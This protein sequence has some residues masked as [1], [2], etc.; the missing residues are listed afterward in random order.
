VLAWL[1]NHVV[2][3]SFS[4][5]RLKVGLGLMWE[6]NGRSTPPPSAMDLAGR[7]PSLATALQ[8]GSRRFTRE[9]FASFEVEYLRFEDYVHVNGV[10][11]TPVLP[12]ATL[13]T[14][15]VDDDELNR[16]FKLQQLHMDT[17]DEA[18]QTGPNEFCFSDTFT[19]RQTQVDLS[20]GS[21]TAISKS[22][23]EDGQIISGHM[24]ASG[25]KWRNAGSSRPE[26]GYEFWNQTLADSLQEKTEFTDQ[27]WAAFGVTD[28]NACHFIKSGN[29]FFR[30]AVRDGPTCVVLPGEPEVNGLIGAAERAQA[31]GADH[32]T[33]QYKREYKL[34]LCDIR[35]DILVAQPCAFEVR[36]LTVFFQSNWSTQSVPVY[37]PDIAPPT[38][39]D[40]KPLDFDVCEVVWNKAKHNRLAC[41]SLVYEVELRIRWANEDAGSPR[42][43]N[44]TVQVKD[45]AIGH[46][47]TLSTRFQNL[48]LSHFEIRVRVKSGEF[49]AS[50]QVDSALTEN[51]LQTSWSGRSGECWLPSISAPPSCSATLSKV[52]AGSKWT[53]LGTVAP[54]RGVELVCPA[55]SEAISS[56][57]D[58]TNQELESFKVG[59]LR[60]DH[61]VRSRRGVYFKAVEWAANVEWPDCFIKH[62]RGW[63]HSVPYQVPCEIDSFEVNITYAMW[64]AQSGKLNDFEEKT[65]VLEAPSTPFVVPL[66]H[67]R[68]RFAVR[69]KTK[70]HGFSAWSAQSSGDAYVCPPRAPAPLP[71][72]LARVKA[73]SIELLW[74][75]F[76]LGLAFCVEDGTACCI[77][78]ERKRGR[79]ENDGGGATESWESLQQA[80]ETDEYRFVQCS[81]D[82]SSGRKIDSPGCKLSVLLDDA[83]SLNKG[84]EYTYRMR[85]RGALLATDTGRNLAGE[86]SARVPF[87]SDWSEWFVWTLPFVHFGPAQ[88]PTVR[89]YGPHASKIGLQWPEPHASQCRIEKYELRPV[90]DGTHVPAE[91]DDT[92][93]QLLLDECVD[94]GR[95]DVAAL[96]TGAGVEPAALMVRADAAQVS[97]SVEDSCTGDEVT[98]TM[99]LP[100]G[101][102]PSGWT[103]PPGSA[104][105][106]KVRAVVTPEPCFDSDLFEIEGFRSNWSMLSDPRIIPGISAPEFAS[107]E[108]MNWDTATV[109]WNE[110]SKRF[111]CQITGYEMTW[112]E[113]NKVDVVPDDGGNGGIV[114]ADF[115][116][117]VRQS[118]EKRTCTVSHL[119]AGQTLVFAVKVTAQ[120]D[121]LPVTIHSPVDW[122]PSMAELEGQHII[123][124]TVPHLP[125][126]VQLSA[127]PSAWAKSEET[128]SVSSCA[129]SWAMPAGLV[130][131]AG[132][133]ASEFVL[134][135]RNVSADEA[136]QD[137]ICE[138]VLSIDDGQTISW[139]CG[140]FAQTLEYAFRVR[141]RCFLPPRTPPC[142]L[143]PSIEQPLTS[144]WSE[145]TRVTIPGVGVPGKVA[146]RLLGPRPTLCH[147]MW[148]WPQT[149]GGCYFD[150]FVLEFNLPGMP[151]FQ[152]TARNASYVYN[153]F[154]PTG[155]NASTDNVGTYSFE[156]RVRARARK[157]SKTFMGD[158]SEPLAVSMPSIS[159]PKNLWIDPLAPIPSNNDGIL[160]AHLLGH[161]FRALWSP[162]EVLHANKSDLTYEIRVFRLPAKVSEGSV[163]EKIAHQFVPYYEHA[164]G[165]AW[166][167]TGDAV[168]SVGMELTC[169]ELS[170]ALDSKLEFTKDEWASFG[171]RGL[172]T[173]NFVKSHAGMYFRPADEQLG[174]MS[175]QCWLDVSLQH[176]NDTPK[177]KGSYRYFC[178]VNVRLEQGEV[179]LS[180]PLSFKAATCDPMMMP[181]LDTPRV[182][183]FDGDGRQYRDAAELIWPPCKAYHCLDDRALQF[184]IMEVVHQKKPK[185]PDQPLFPKASGLVWRC[186]P[187]SR[188][189][190]GTRLVHAKLAKA[191][192]LKTEFTPDEW[193]AFGV[194][195]LRLSH[196]VEVG[197]SCYQPVAARKPLSVVF[198]N[199]DGS[200]RETFDAVKVSTDQPSSKY[201]KHS[202]RAQQVSPVHIDHKGRMHVLV[203]CGPN[204]GG[205]AFQVR[206]MAVFRSPHHVA[207]TSLSHTVM[208]SKHIAAICETEVGAPISLYLCEAKDDLLLI[209]T[210]RK[211]GLLPFDSKLIKRPVYWGP[212]TR[213]QSGK[214][215]DEG[216]SGNAAL[217]YLQESDSQ[218]PSRW[219]VSQ[220]PVDTSGR[221]A[222]SARP[223][224]RPAPHVPS[225]KPHFV[226]TG[227]IRWV[228]ELVSG[229]VHLDV[230][231]ES[232]GLRWRLVG[233]E[234]PSRGAEVELS[235]G[236]QRAALLSAEGNDGAFV[237]FTVAQLNRIAL[238]LKWT[239]F[240]SQPL[241]GKQLRNDLLRDALGAATGTSGY[242][243]LSQADLDRLRSQGGLDGLSW[244]CVVKVGDA[245]Y[246]PH[247]RELTRDSFI[248]VPRASGLKWRHFGSHRPPTG[249]ELVSAPLSMALGNK[250]EFT[251]EELG[252]LGVSN[253]R[254]THFVRVGQSFYQPSG[255][256]AS[257]FVPDARLTLINPALSADANIVGGGY[258][259]TPSEHVTGPNKV[260]FVQLPELSEAFT[261]GPKSK[262]VEKLLQQMALDS[263][264]QPP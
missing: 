250:S 258:E 169:P 263:A 228:Q 124:L 219:I 39:V 30:P 74:P 50:V 200:E 55:L 13:A 35:Q 69:A 201:A 48:R 153:V 246:K 103:A 255:E 57:T 256:Q 7:Y 59:S 159:A 209:G 148:G 240:P 161:T 142:F 247:A 232:L 83:S 170:E 100:D 70:L 162:P 109:A 164:S 143:S 150:G 77:Q 197:H 49:P 152:K 144:A 222:V 234:R 29:S 8:S 216:G 186:L 218:D 252:A 132:M 251:R 182:A 257:Y 94:D 54:F 45:D 154:D 248:R 226:L 102:F 172:R 221:R 61:F 98:N 189:P 91:R 40:I 176:E 147:L 4:K 227:R 155:E 86:S 81:A 192:A 71:P 238:G 112:R 165:L 46:R 129:V 131:P 9:E 127:V 130:V 190:T 178:S 157:D 243:E 6:E 198:R 38:L 47:E 32:R 33:G 208:T 163:P 107:I 244:D 193:D 28:L 51:E 14:V 68:H 261:G 242:A 1:P 179:D 231:N 99:E 133:V 145:Q 2:Y 78:F 3:E 89:L 158:W 137:V 203:Q 104:I 204:S 139:T 75:G 210:K 27:E 19:Q 126:P 10:T 229:F 181:D 177:R 15:A 18:Q 116:Q 80:G 168:P 97:D 21:W 92:S 194:R 84:V 120:A 160:D 88:Q 24:R 223:G 202:D 241:E 123:T 245:W 11:Y 65:L 134:Q 36:A 140:G 31:I 236:M 43:E 207:L 118:A 52:Q 96:P 117:L 105:Q 233:E 22:K 259:Y 93:V 101:V 128:K 26:A 62:G 249:T 122:P 211:Q 42:C 167:A 135:Q 206:A 73:R 235:D 171:V 114:A 16:F 183:W 175:D 199:S 174:I 12:E 264:S 215:K 85:A 195:D 156:I 217:Y 82:G 64:R 191:L 185:W 260:P 66:E 214:D 188:P 20:L 58:F 149:T 213:E 25:V 220:Q 180:E 60:S 106:C 37:V 72:K 184:E 224:E 76:P 253:V 87:N 44:Q 173:D 230:D 115:T 138:D 111:A 53:K 113:S 110:P 34:T 187:S 17:M 254:P 67:T 151:A 23:N 239:K 95:H 205:L 212:N 119:R 125:P 63:R 79:P 5:Y 262:R 237:E 141:A 166:A 90:F 225:E 136:W 108:M 41:E 196:F 121:G 56:K 146:R